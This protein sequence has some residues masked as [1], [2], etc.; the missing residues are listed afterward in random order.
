MGVKPPDLIMQF[1]KGG[2]P[3]AGYLFLGAEPFYRGRCREALLEAVLGSDRDGSSVTEIDLRQEPLT[4]LIEEARTMSLFASNRL[5]I[6]RSAEGALPRAAS[7]ASKAEQDRL[8]RYFADPSPG[9]VVLLEAV[10]FDSRERDERDRLARIG[11]YYSAVPVR[12]ELNALSGSD[13]RY[14]AGVLARRMQLRITEDVLNEFVEMLGAD[15][16]RIEH[17]LEKLALYVGSGREVTGEDIDLL[18]PEARQTGAFEFSQAVAAG[19]CAQALQLLDTMSRSGI[20]WPGQINLVAGLFRQ[21]LAA[22]E[23]GLG[24]WRQINS[25]FG[26]HGMRT[27]PSR[28][29]QIAGIVA[30]FREEELRRALVLLFEADRGLRSPGPDDRLVVESLVIRLTR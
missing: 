29:R 12:I 2:R 11:R 4:A 8:E 3:A 5:V 14:I 23:L 19:N 15:A 24:D 27:W 10:R 28:S 6:G 16:F 21:A 9:T 18:V 25:R 7:A 22:K 17:E 13:A 30:R 26:S 20:Y 1:R